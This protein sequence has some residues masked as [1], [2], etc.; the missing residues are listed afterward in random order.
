MEHREPQYMGTAI[1]ISPTHGRS[2]TRQYPEVVC[3]I[4]AEIIYGALPAYLLWH[5]QKKIRTDVST[6]R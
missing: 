5:Q 3:I 4:V 6:R 2:P 1:A